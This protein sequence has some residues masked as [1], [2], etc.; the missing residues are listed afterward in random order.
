MKKLLSYFCVYA[1]LGGAVFTVPQLHAQHTRDV[2]LHKAVAIYDYMRGDQQQAIVELSS[3]SDHNGMEFSGTR[4]RKLARL[5]QLQKTFE[6]NLAGEMPDSLNNNLWI[7]ISSLHYAEGDCQGALDALEEVRNLTQERDH[8]ARMLRVTCMLDQ[9]S[10]SAGV[11]AAAENIALSAEGTS[12][13]LAYIYNNIAAAAGYMEDYTSAQRYYLKAKEYTDTTE[14]GLA[15]ASRIRLS[16]AWSYY[17]SLRY[18]YA[19]KEFSQLTVDNEWVDLSLLGYGWAAFKNSQPGLA[20]EAW[21]QLIY[22]PFKSISVYE[23]FLAIPYAMEKQNAYSEALAAYKAAAAR[24]AEQISK[25]DEL[26]ASITAQE[27]EQHA[28]EYARS[29]GEPITPLHPLLV[30]AFSRGDFQD[31]FDVIAELDAFVLRLQAFEKT[32]KVLDEARLFMVR[33]IG[34][35]DEQLAKGEAAVEQ[36]LQGLFAN[37]EDLGA[38]ILVEGMASKDVSEKLKAKYQRYQLLQRSVNSGAASN[39]KSMQ[40]SL[41][42]V[43]NILLGDLEE[44]LKERGDDSLISTARITRLA[45]SYRLLEQRYQSYWAM[46]PYANKKDVGGPQLKALQKRID[47]AKQHVVTVQKKIDQ[48]LIAKT[49][50]A[51]AEQKEQLVIFE[52]QAR[53]ALARLSEE[54]YQRG[55]RKLWH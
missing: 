37:L 8:E 50:Q 36:Q 14:E 43:R 55:G 35:N 52:D 30:D 3:E 26:A 28:V 23:G 11:L 7:D 51:L 33:N 34:N 22:L 13:Y 32:V 38:K 1:T 49:Q 40:T 18:D 39:Q 20:V 42:R 17:E 45:E 29:H 5:E 21:R 10:L 24:Y 15:L 9:H 4:N 47:V 27:I 31:V 54:F 53:I 12:I 46:K 44:E 2:S 16:L 19:L 6:L 41:K 25:V 48:L